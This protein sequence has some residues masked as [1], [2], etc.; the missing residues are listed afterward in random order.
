MTVPLFCILYYFNTGLPTRPEFGNLVPGPNAGEITISLKTSSSG[1][2]GDSSEVFWFVV[3]PIHEG[4]EGESVSHL[5][6]NYQSG[7]FET[8]VV[9]GLVEG[10]SYILNAKAVNVYGSSQSASSV[11]VI[12][13]K[14]ATHNEIILKTS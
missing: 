5:S 10:K 4:D 7:T 2:N 8:I 9:S 13:G 3:I 12:A 6:L 14:S 11:S 1:I